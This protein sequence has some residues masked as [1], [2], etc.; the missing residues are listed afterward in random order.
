MRTLLFFVFLI[1]SQIG[2]GQENLGNIKGTVTDKKGKPVDFAVVRVKDSLKFI[3]YDMTDDDGIFEIKGLPEGT[4]SIW[5]ESDF[6]SETILENVKIRKDSTQVI[7]ITLSEIEFYGCPMGRP[8]P[9][10]IDMN[11]RF[12]GTI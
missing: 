8:L 3:A 11:G 9:K 4:Y 10:L 7:N 2:F 5:F 1:S 12:N 6:S